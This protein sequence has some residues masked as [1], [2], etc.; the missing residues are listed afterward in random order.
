MRF[1]RK[2]SLCVIGAGLALGA[3]CA[4]AFGDEVADRAKDPNLWAAPGGDQSLTRHSA[5]KD[6]STS[7]V[8][9][10]QM[11]WSQSSGTLRGHEGQPLVVD[12]RRQ[13]DDVHG[14][15]LAEH[16]PGTRPE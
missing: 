3:F 7:N 16:R 8:G 4:A 1:E 5:L 6:I 14:E 12:G 9:N 13:A 15:R 11:V 10:L 2:R